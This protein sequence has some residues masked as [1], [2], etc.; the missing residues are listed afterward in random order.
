[1]EDA[2]EMVLC[3]YCEQVMRRYTPEY[4]IGLRKAAGVS[5]VE[6]AKRLHLTAQYI[7]DIEHGRRRFTPR[8]ERAYLALKELPREANH[9]GHS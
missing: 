2:T 9:D 7:S 5:A 4:L 1:M 3:H 8:L 6:F